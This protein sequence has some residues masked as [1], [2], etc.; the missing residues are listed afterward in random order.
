MKSK[1]LEILPC[2]RCNAVPSFYPW[3]SEE[4][5]KLHFP[6]CNCKH[7]T[8]DVCLTIE[9]NEYAYRNRNKQSVVRKAS[10]RSAIMRWNSNVNRLVKRKLGDGLVTCK[11]CKRSDLIWGKRPYKSAWNGRKLDYVLYERVK[12][13][14]NSEPGIIINSITLGGHIIKP[15]KYVIH[16][17]LSRE[18]IVSVT[19]TKD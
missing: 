3:P 15:M 4:F 19:Y 14:D 17:C 18:N 6:V 7:K 1:E 11:F 10:K 16:N 8:A 2:R 9:I 12:L 5:P 13:P